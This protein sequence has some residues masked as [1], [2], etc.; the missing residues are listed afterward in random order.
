MERTQTYE[1]VKKAVQS[2]FVGRNRGGDPEAHL[3]TNHPDL[4]ASE[5]ENLEG[6]IPSIR[7]AIL[8]LSLGKRALRHRRDDERNHKPSIPVAEAYEV[9]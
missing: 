7:P 4:W 9:R 1:Q 6:E 5:D 8:H 2:K 3:L